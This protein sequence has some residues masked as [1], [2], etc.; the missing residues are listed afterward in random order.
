[1]PPK[2]RR[3]PSLQ[4]SVIIV[5][6]N[7]REF[8]H[9]ALT[10]LRKSMKGIRGEVFVV[11]NASDDGSVEMVRTRFPDVRLIVNKTNIGFASANN[12]ALRRSRGKVILLLNPDTVVQEDTMKVMLRFFEDNPDAGIAGCKILNPDG[13]LQLPCRRS[14]PT[15]WVALAK[16][17]GLSSLFPGSRLFGRYNLTYLSPEETYEVDAVSGS[18]MM[19]RREAYEGVGGLDESFFM[20]GE[21]LDWCYRVQQAGWKN[22]Y[23]HSTQIIHYKG[24]STRRSSI[25]EIRMFYDA[26]HL[27]VQKH[28]HGSRPMTF[29]LRC[30][31]VVS[32]WMAMIRQFL[33]PM[34]AALVDATLIV[35]GLMLAEYIR[36]GQLFYFPAY[37]YPAAY[38]IPTVLIVVGLYAA[39]VYTHRRMSASQTVVVVISSYIVVAALVAFFKEYAFSRLVIVLA[40][41]ITA[42]VLPGWR[43]LIRFLGKTGPDG[44]G[45]L[46]WRRAIIVGVD[47]SARSLQKRLRRRVGDGYEVVG[48]VDFERKRIG[49]LLD[50]VPIIGSVDNVGKIVQEYRIHDVMFSTG[51]LSYAS[52]LSVI[53]RTSGRSVNYHLVP[54]TLEV[55]IGKAT[56]DSLNDLPLVQISYNIERAGNKIMKRAIDL[57]FSAVLLISLYPFVYFK[58]VLTGVSPST[59]LLGLPEVFVGR[60]SFVGPPERIASAFSQNGRPAPSAH[61]GKPGLTGLVQLHSGRNLTSEEVDQYNLYYA[62]N[63][64]LFL[65][66]EIVLKSL[67][68]RRT[69][70]IPPA[71]TPPPKHRRGTQVKEASHG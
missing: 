52:I 36:M 59:V 9:H 63:Q 48:F 47:A 61:L 69:M 33:K 64:S 56:V 31:I 40:G 11:D 41:V 58:R 21:D 6:Y 15:A 19:M 5:N 16:I 26:M 24:E 54:T 8:L 27:F 1:M 57:V 43:L 10:S 49:E 50:G 44:T 53:A 30:G 51:K 4:L 17:S 45:F 71:S 55:M 65:D 67:L 7:V 60:K 3:S 22:Y 14:F 23:V 70:T 25:D 62:K 68:R 39:G 12:I 42:I 38:T 37:A 46:F 18:F 35:L 13:S 34:G 28:L 32:S 66:I 29:V 2:R 20:Y